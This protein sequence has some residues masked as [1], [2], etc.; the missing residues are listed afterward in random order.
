MFTTRSLK[1]FLY[2]IGSGRR[3]LLVFL[4][5]ALITTDIQ[6]QNC[7]DGLVQRQALIKK[8]V[9]ICCTVADGSLAIVITTPWQPSFTAE[10]CLQFN[11]G[12]FIF[13]EVANAIFG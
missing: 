11:C 8:I 6:V 1:C 12:R 5:W 3:F 9:Q 10:C 4:L 13:V 2:T 7:P